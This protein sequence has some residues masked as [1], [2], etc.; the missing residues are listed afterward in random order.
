[1]GRSKKACGKLFATD[2]RKERAPLMDAGV[3]SCTS[4]MA[5]KTS[6]FCMSQMEELPPPTP[7]MTRIESYRAQPLKMTLETIEEDKPD[8]FQRS[9]SV[10]VQRRFS[11][12]STGHGLHR[13]PSHRR[14]GFGISFSSPLACQQGEDECSDKP[15]RS[16]LCRMREAL[17][18]HRIRRAF[19]RLFAKL[20]PQSRTAN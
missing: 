19:S 20:R 13:L 6:F 10:P 15:H 8:L 4:Y 2:L 1:M 3:N 5:D 9:K 7:R 11:L 18:C 17:R 16:R 14:D 12:D